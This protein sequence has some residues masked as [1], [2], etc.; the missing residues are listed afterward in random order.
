[1]RTSREASERSMMS[2]LLDPRV[3]TGGHLSGRREALVDCCS[4]AMAD[5]SGSG[6]QVAAWATTQKPL[7]DDVGGC[8]SIRS[9]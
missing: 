4:E 5:R 9:L 2:S 3:R 6:G 8:F 1:M 7:R